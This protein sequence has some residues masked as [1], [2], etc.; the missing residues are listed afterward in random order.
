M[1]EAVLVVLTKAVPGMEADMEDWYTNIHIRD[2]L[3]FR[4]SATAQRF[5]YSASQ[6]AAPERFEWQYLA[7]YD[8]FDPERFAREHLEN[9]LTSRMQVTQAID[10]T[11]LYDFHYYPLQFRDN[12]PG[13][14]HKGGVIFEEF[15]P[16]EGR[17]DDFRRWYES[18]YLPAA[19]QVPGVK[20]GAFLMYRSF[21]QMIPMTPD[22]SYVAIYRINDAAAAQAWGD[23]PA[24]IAAS[25]LIG[26]EDVRITR[27]DQATPKITKDAVQ[28]PT[29]AGLAEEERARAHMGERVKTGGAEKL[30]MG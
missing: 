8:V 20:S 9:A 22:Y 18:E 19:M 1:I 23:A 28:H 25:R 14:P 4:G 26:P 6:P 21:G 7:F 5:A 17:E 15:R 27:W 3:R 24:R 12:D 13:T 16:S 10:D 2:A 11:V 29:A 30:S